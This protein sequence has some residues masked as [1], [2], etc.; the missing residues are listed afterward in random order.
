M[1]E[2]CSGR[3]WK[4]TVTILSKMMKKRPEGTDGESHVDIWGNIPGREYSEC[5]D[6][7][8]GQCTEYVREGEAKRAGKE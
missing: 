6:S 1:I 5:K 8:A 4:L 3:E 2:G 7:E